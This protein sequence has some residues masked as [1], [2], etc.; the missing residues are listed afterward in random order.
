VT[1]HLIDEP[2]QLWN[3]ARVSAHQ[4]ASAFSTVARRGFHVPC[5]AI[6]LKMYGLDTSFNLGGDGTAAL[7]DNPDAGHPRDQVLRFRTAGGNGAA[8][9]AQDIRFLPHGAPITTSGDVESGSIA[10]MAT[11]HWRATLAVS[12]KRGLFFGG[13]DEAVD[14]AAPECAV[15]F[16]LFGARWKV[17]VGGKR[18]GRILPQGEMVAVHIAGTATTLE[19]FTRRQGEPAWTLEYSGTGLSLAALRSVRWGLWSTANS[20]TSVWFADWALSDDFAAIDRDFWLAGSG[21]RDAAQTEARPVLIVPDGLLRASKARVR[22]VA[23]S[24]PSAGTAGSWADLSGKAQSALPLPI[25]G[26]TP[27]TAYSYRFEL[28]TSDGTVIWTSGTY[29]FRTAAEAGTAQALQIAFGSCHIQTPLAHPHTEDGYIVDEA[30][31]DYFATFHLG[32]HLYEGGGP[33]SMKPA[34]MQGNPPVT[35]SDYQRMTRE[36]FCDPV[37]VRLFERGVYDFQPDDHETINQI[38][39]RHKPGGSKANDLA[40]AW[41]GRRYEEYG[42]TTMGALWTAGMTVSAAMFTDHRIGTPGGGVLYRHKVLGNVEL[43][44]L[45]TRYERNPATSLFISPTQMAWLKD[46]IDNILPTTELV[47]FVAQGAFGAYMSKVEEGWESVAPAQFAEFWDYACANVAPK[48]QM[49]SGDDHVCFAHHFLHASAATPVYPPNCFGETRASGGAAAEFV[50]TSGFAAWRY[51]LNELTSATDFLRS[52]PV[53]FDISA[54]ADEVNL[55]AFANGTEYTYAL[56]SPAAFAAEAGADLVE[57]WNPD[58]AASVFSDTGASTPATIGGNA[59]A[60]VG[61]KLGKTLVSAAAP[62]VWA[63]DTVNGLEVLS[64]NAATPNRLSLTDALFTDTFNG[65][66]PFGVVMAVKRSATDVAGTLFAVVDGGSTNNQRIAA[67]INSS[68][69]LTMTRASAGGATTTI[70]SSGENIGT[71]WEIIGVLSTGFSARLY[72][73]G[74]L[75]AS[76]SIGA[77]TSAISRLVL[78]ARHQRSDDTYVNGH[79]GLI[80]GMSILNAGGVTRSFLDRMDHFIAV[81]NNIDVAA[82]LL[83]GPADLATSDTTATISVSTDTANGTLYWYLSTSA[84]PPS[85]ADLKAGTGAAFSG[86]QAVSATGVQTKNLTGLAPS[87]VYYAH[88]L[89]SDAAG[90]DSAVASADGF[91]TV[92][93][94]TLLGSATGGAVSAGSFTLDLS[95]LSLQEDDFVVVTV[96]GGGQSS[97]APTVTGNQSGTYSAAG[98]TAYADSSGDVN[99]GMFTKK[100]GATPDTSL[101]VTCLN[102]ASRASGA[103]AQVFRYVDETT[104]LDATG[105]VATLTTGSR[106]DPPAVTPT[107]AGALVVSGGAGSQQIGGS[108]AAPT[109]P[110]GMANETSHLVTSGATTFYMGV[111]MASAPWTSGAYDPPAWTGGATNANCAAAAQTIALRP[112]YPG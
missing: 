42:T 78:A 59:A 58:V 45:D 40:A 76:G 101:T 71:D 60:L 75:V 83:S 64:C 22:W 95:G 8:F 3:P 105:T 39:V 55:S 90:N 52:S 21:T 96:G 66:T 49:V 16:T 56:L 98:G 73:N 25:T 41:P 99:F 77:A 82:P 65:N 62:P 111:W 27:N 32:D 12:G 1:L 109:V 100:M 61:R 50:S 37:Q 102:S 15:G 92:Q 57:H 87:T 104:P 112:K 63:S 14:Q 43:I 13:F 69:E 35:A 7:A 97:S 79:P 19:V 68:N 36:F 93:P 11:W 26:L 106:G 70:G 108:F 67:S 6:S 72:R 20:D 5:D 84:T 81:W 30:G 44:F 23:G 88:F 86:S 38:D 28:A 53:L 34:Y 4:Q 33:N 29:R 85:P 9:T 10:S 2:P 107:T 94:I 18:Y 46:R 51:P 54:D 31:D 103:V 24:D 89:H 91:T 48:W 17:T 80:G 110:S 74:R 47:L